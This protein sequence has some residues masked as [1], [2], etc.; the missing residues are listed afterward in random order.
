MAVYQKRDALIL[1]SSKQQKKG[2]Y[3]SLLLTMAERST[4]LSF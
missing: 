2:Q 3:F 4:D 1:S